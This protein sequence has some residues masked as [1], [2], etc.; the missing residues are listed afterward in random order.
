MI[1]CVLETRVRA[2]GGDRPAAVVNSGAVLLSCDEAQSPGTDGGPCL[3]ISVTAVWVFPPSG[4]LT[5]TH[6]Q[7]TDIACLDLLVTSMFIS[8]W[9]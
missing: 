9:D 1:E 2:L 7:H 4:P 6:T 5:H 3:S 8:F